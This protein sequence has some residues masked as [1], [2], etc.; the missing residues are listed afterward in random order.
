[1][2]NELG[3]HSLPPPP[4]NRHCECVSASFLLSPQVEDLFGCADP[5]WNWNSSAPPSHARKT[6]CCIPSLASSM[7]CIERITSFVSIFYNFGALRLTY[8]L[9]RKRWLVSSFAEF[10]KQKIQVAVPKELTA[11]GG[12]MKKRDRK[13]KL[14][15]KVITCALSCV[16]CFHQHESLQQCECPRLM[17]L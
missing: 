10:K 11:W 9:A 6:F 12:K 14:K 17:A 15:R 3:S 5:L 16:L 13:A 4:T 8:P 1:M 7:D 2:R